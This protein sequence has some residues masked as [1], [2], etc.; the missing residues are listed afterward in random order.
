MRNLGG[1]SSACSSRTRPAGSA[2]LYA[3]V[4]AVV[5]DERGVMEAAWVGDRS[6]CDLDRVARD[7]VGL[8][9]YPSGG[10]GPG[11]A[12]RVPVGRSEREHD[13]GRDLSTAGCE[14][15]QGVR[16]RAREVARVKADVVDVGDDERLTQRPVA[17]LRQVVACAGQA[18]RQRVV[19]RTGQRP[20]RGRD[21]EQE[22]GR[23]R[24]R[25]GRGLS[26]TGRH[27]RCHAQRQHSDHTNHRQPLG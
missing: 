27:Q 23:R 13:G 22:A 9:A 21:R 8:L 6:W 5:D 11:R 4:D 2:A 19:A 20:R 3:V 25:D 10:D 26:A 18:Q 14:G 7:V 15:E 17:E 1:G 24:L 16:L 12:A